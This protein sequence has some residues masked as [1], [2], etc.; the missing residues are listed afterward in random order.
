MFFINYKTY[1]YFYTID[2]EWKLYKHSLFVYEPGF[3][4]S[5]TDTARS[6]LQ[7]MEKKEIDEILFKR[8]T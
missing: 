5:K 4:G 3:L 7:K 2:L 8:L 1:Q 6:V